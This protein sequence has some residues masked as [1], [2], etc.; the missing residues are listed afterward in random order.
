ML[1]LRG[2]KNNGEEIPPSIF[3]CVVSKRQF[4]MYEYVCTR[5]EEEDL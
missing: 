4:F 2:E 3:V 1:A 5:N